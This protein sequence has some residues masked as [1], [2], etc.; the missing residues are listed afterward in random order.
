VVGLQAEEEGF[1]AQRVPIPKYIYGHHPGARVERLIL[2]YENGF[3]AR[4]ARDAQREQE[5]R[6]DFYELLGREM[7]WFRER[8]ASE[9]EARE[10]LRLPRIDAAMMEGKFDPVKAIF[11]QEGMERRFERKWK[12]L[13][14]YRQ[15]CRRGAE[16]VPDDQNEATE[17]QNRVALDR[18]RNEDVESKQPAEE[19]F[20]DAGI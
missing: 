20:T 15:T 1:T 5:C 16:R 2:I 3:K 12:L 19:A 10:E 4:K 8:A 13:E 14:K 7:A 17:A 9:R 11:Y 18:R 6:T